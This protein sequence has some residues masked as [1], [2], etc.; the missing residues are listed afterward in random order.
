[1]F[2][3][4]MIML[5]CVIAVIF[6]C[7]APEIPSAGDYPCLPTIKEL[8]EEYA[9]NAHLL[10]G[11]YSPVPINRNK[12]N[13]TEYADDLMDNEPIN[14]F[15]LVERVSRL[16]NVR[17]RFSCQ[18]PPFEITDEELKPY[19]LEYAPNCLFRNKLINQHPSFAPVILK[20]AE[21][22]GS[23]M[24]SSS[25]DADKSE[26]WGTGFLLQNRIIATTCHIIA[27]LVDKP[28]NASRLE[29]DGDLWIDFGSSYG[30]HKISK[31]FVKCSKSKGLDVA[32]LKLVDNPCGAPE[33]LPLP[34]TLAKNPPLELNRSDPAGVYG[35]VAYADMEHPI[36]V[37]AQE[38]YDPIRDSINKEFSYDVIR[39]SDC[40]NKTVTIY[41]ESAGTTMGQSGGPL[42]DL[43]R[44]VSDPNVTSLDVIGI[45]ICCSEY[46]SF[47]KGTP[48]DQKMYCAQVRRTIDNQAV[49]SAS[50]WSDPDLN[51]V[52]SEQPLGKCKK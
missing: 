26:M 52:L 12:H 42:F 15:N 17:K 31:D 28:E 30:K 2:I 23:L 8:K 34:L 3:I 47:P 16:D 1:M 29:F 39:K 10:A 21:S 48:P 45:H 13:D 49:S 24:V 11:F 38:L 35:L 22:V 33:T 36:D 37:D 19:G 51:S 18:F 27:P 7:T 9:K 32:L 44:V 43:S 5:S 50:V 14:K 40:S 41:L 25:T 20:S 46:F 6:G 4:G